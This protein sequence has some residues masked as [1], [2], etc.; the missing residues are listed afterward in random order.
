M[1]AA[2]ETLARG[3]SERALQYAV[4]E[5]AQR[6]GWLVYHPYDSRKSE[7]GYP[8]LTL[9]GQRGLLFAELKSATGRLT[10]AQR[11]WHL[12]FDLAGARIVVWRPAD[13]LSGRV[14]AV[15]RG[16]ETG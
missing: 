16:E 12:A 8:D 15:L 14:E 13:W 6:L 1:S 7:P 4:I 5:C 3:M 9:V 11:M 2:A 10:G